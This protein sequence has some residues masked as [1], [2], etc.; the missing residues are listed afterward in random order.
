MN[1]FDMVLIF[2]LVLLIVRAFAVIHSDRKKGKGCLGCSGDCS[3]CSLHST[4]KD[5]R[6]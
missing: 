2:L 4:I 1:T 5:I 3:S 6:S